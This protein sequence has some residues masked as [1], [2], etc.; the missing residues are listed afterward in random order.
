[1]NFWLRISCDKC[2][3]MNEYRLKKIVDKHNDGRPFQEFTAIARS[4]NS[5]GG[6]FN[7]E[8]NKIKCGNCGNKHD[9]FI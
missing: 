2:G 9:L 7:A 5:K 4:L 1:M 6:L 3:Y 8:G